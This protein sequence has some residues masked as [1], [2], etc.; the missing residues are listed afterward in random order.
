M[1]WFAI[2]LVCFHSIF[3]VFPEDHASQVLQKV[4]SQLRSCRN[5]LNLVDGMWNFMATSALAQQKQ[6][7]GKGIWC[8]R[9]FYF[10]QNPWHG[11]NTCTPRSVLWRASSSVAQMPLG[12]KPGRLLGQAG[13]LPREEYA[14]I[15]TNRLLQVHH[16]LP[17]LPRAS[18]SWSEI[19][20]TFEVMHCIL[21]NLFCELMHWAV[22]PEAW[23]SEA[24]SK[25]QGYAAS[26]PISPL[27]CTPLF[28]HHFMC[29]FALLGFYEDSM[30]HISPKM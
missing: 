15:W 8:S 11:L 1:L 12:C 13:A 27:K 22:F 29:L 5:I 7:G 16:P 21:A 20:I 25:T 18:I 2:R 28:V 19:D 6:T 9:G 23:H 26:H 30:L 17:A 10:G 3:T 14:L 4:Q 24:Q